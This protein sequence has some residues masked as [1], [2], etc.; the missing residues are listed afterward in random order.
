MRTLK[1]L[2]KNFKKQVATLIELINKFRVLKK[3]LKKFILTSSLL[4]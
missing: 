3:N 2:E 1:N 4:F